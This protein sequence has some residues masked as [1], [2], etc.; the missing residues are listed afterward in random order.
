MLTVSCGSGSGDHTNE[1]NTLVDDAPVVTPTAIAD[2]PAAPAGG[3]I[4]DGTYVLS[5]LTLHTG[6]GGSTQTTGGQ[7]S[8]VFQIQGMT[9]QQVGTAGGEEK[10]YTSTFV[11][12]GSTV[13]MTDSCPMPKTESHS[14]TAT[15]TEFHI[16]D[17]LPTGTAEQV[18]SRR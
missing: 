9:M 3:T 11:T 8:A 2:S 14:F 6:P 4:A 17:M 7:A 15:A 16:F 13:T 1:C 10:R 5:V 12:S 18:Y